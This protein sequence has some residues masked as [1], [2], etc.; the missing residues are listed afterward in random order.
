MTTTE[1][2]DDIL[3]IAT[4][5][6]SKTGDKK[7][8]DPILLQFSIDIQ[9]NKLIDAQ[10]DT[11]KDLIGDHTQALEDL[12]SPIVTAINGIDLHH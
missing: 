11:L 2:I 8:A 1:I 6:K 4:T 5:L 7:I 9:R 12:E 3:S 10:T